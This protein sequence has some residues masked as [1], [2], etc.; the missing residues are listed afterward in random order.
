MV[1]NNVYKT[2]NSLNIYFMRSQNVEEFIR[3]SRSEEI[4][5]R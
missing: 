1:G 4:E 3:Q 2:I 5:F